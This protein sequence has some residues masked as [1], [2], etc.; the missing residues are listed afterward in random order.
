MPRNKK[1]RALTGTLL[2][3]LYAMDNSL[4]NGKKPLLD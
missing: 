3:N 4:M 2:K 1:E